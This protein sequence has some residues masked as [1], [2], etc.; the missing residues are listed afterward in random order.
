MGDGWG[1]V[2]STPQPPMLAPRTGS[3]RAARRYDRGFDWRYAA[4]PPGPEAASGALLVPIIWDGLPLDPG[5]SPR[6]GA[7][8]GR[9]ERDRLA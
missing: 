9:R 1:L 6:D 2:M 3:L 7:L 8:H 5:D 4:P